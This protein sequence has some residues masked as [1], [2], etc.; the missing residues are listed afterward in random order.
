VIGLSFLV[1]VQLAVSGV[2]PVK[3]LFYSQVVAGLVAPFLVVLLVLLT[4]SRKVMGD[5]TNG[6]WTKV[7]GILAVV[8]LVV[9]DVALIYSV[10]TSGLP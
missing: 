9:A 2:D 8:V 10:A 1:G 7:M 3:G 6:L 5:F 4:S